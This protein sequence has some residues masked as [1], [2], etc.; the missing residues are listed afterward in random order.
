MVLMS[1]A[2]FA[3]SPALTRTVYDATL[4]NGFTIHHLRHE[5]NGAVTRLYTTETDFLDVPTAQIAEMTES[6][7]AL[8]REAKPKMSIPEAVNAASDKHQIDAD[9]IN[10]VIHA[11]SAFNPRA[12]SSKGALGLMQ[13]MPGTASQLGVKDAYDPAANVDGGTQYLRELLEKYNGDL[14]KALAAYNA[15]PGRVQQYKGVP[16]YRET[17]AYVARIVR[18]FNQKKLAQQKAAKAA[19]TQAAKAK[20][21]ETGKGQ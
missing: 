18:E 16:P 21:G 9:L 1:A 6:E 11:E 8:P 12:R 10:S 14:I 2:A 20:T 19:A 15:G 13:L 7:E 5:V 4:T 17:Q 3:A